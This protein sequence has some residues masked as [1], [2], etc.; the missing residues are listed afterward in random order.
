MYPLYKPTM[1][2]SEISSLP[3]EKRLGYI[4]TSLSNGTID[5]KIA[6]E[7]MAK[8][9]ED[10]CAK[11][12][13]KLPT[14]LFVSF[15]TLSQVSPQSYRTLV[16]R[17]RSVHLDNMAPPAP[18]P[19]T[20]P[21][22]VADA[23]PQNSYIEFGKSI[24]AQLK[25]KYPTFTPQQVITEKAR[26]WNIKKANPA[27]TNKELLDT[28]PELEDVP[29]SEAPEPQATA[30]SSKKKSIPKYIKTLVWNAHIGENVAQAHCLCCKVTTINMRHFDCGHVISEK[31]GGSLEVCNLRPICKHCNSAMG[32]TNM[33]DFIKT[34][35][36]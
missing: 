9:R 32:S 28:S 7:Y 11:P 15:E 34:F 31:N 36:I 13:K 6:K 14:P 35:G 18:E 2:Y 19:T 20:E 12:V 29:K 24:H 10:E 16:G 30:S 23:P 27:I 1:L 17:P 22:L 33:D 25:E 21:A 3:A 5:A 4:R 26:L 8:S